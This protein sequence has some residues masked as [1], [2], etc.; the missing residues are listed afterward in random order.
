MFENESDYLKQLCA[1]V[2]IS[3]KL[4][5]HS[6]KASVFLNQA[7]EAIK[8]ADEE[9]TKAKEAENKVKESACH[10]V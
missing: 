5:R 9:I 4:K 1:Q 6:E 10:I 7:R 2:L 3:A 8:K